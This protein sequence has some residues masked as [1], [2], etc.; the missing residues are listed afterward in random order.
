M[1]VDSVVDLEQRLSDYRELATMEQ[2]LLASESAESETKLRALE[3]KSAGR[4][5]RHWAY[6]SG[7]SRRL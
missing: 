7:N 2:S 3:Q 4:A 1:L 5:E 6:W